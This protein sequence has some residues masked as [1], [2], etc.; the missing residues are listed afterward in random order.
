MCS[1]SFLCISLR[2]FI[3][4]PI[5]MSKGDVPLEWG[6]VR[7]ATPRSQCVHA[8]KP[9]DCSPSSPG[10]LILMSSPLTSNG[11]VLRF[12]TESQFVRVVCNHS[13][14]GKLENDIS[15]H[16]RHF[17]DMHLRKLDNTF[18]EMHMFS[19]LHIQIS[20]FFST[21]A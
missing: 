4:I 11:R 9:G 14:G 5:F 15:L 21:N 18:T 16:S 10:L 1:M 7:Q 2:S 20:L 6:L 3:C 17:L 8:M 12:T 13:F 19:E